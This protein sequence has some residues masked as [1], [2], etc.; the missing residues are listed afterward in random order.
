M[1]R[2]HEDEAARGEAG[3]RALE[4]IERSHRLSDMLDQTYA[5]YG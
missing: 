2:F 4:V 1:S 3:K 5:L